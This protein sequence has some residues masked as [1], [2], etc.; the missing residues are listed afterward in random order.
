MRLFGY[1][2]RKKRSRYFLTCEKNSSVIQSEYG[3]YK[4]LFPLIQEDMF[5]KAER[6]ENSTKLHEGGS[7]AKSTELAETDK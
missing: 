3:F 5:I 4:K 2:A 1:R 6:E 7:N